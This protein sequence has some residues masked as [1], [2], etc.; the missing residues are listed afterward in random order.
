MRSTAMPY[1]ATRFTATRVTATR[2][3]AMLST[4]PLCDPSARVELPRRSTIKSLAPVATT[5]HPPAVASL[6]CALYSYG[7]QPKALRRYQQRVHIHQ[8]WLRYELP[9]YALHSHAFY[10]DGLLALALRRQTNTDKTHTTGFSTAK[11]CIRAVDL[12]HVST[13]PTLGAYCRVNT[14]T[15]KNLAPVAATSLL[16]PA[17]IPSAK[18]RSTATALPRRAPSLSGE[19]QGGSSSLFST[20]NLN[21]TNTEKKT[22]PQPVFQR[23]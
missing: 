7:A 21:Q 18:T 1:T 19:L 22:H 16:P 8:P 13:G 2:F 14:P 6:R 10:R 4:V 3:T 12:Q 15:K 9:R 5:S 11:Y 23:L 17:V 20:L